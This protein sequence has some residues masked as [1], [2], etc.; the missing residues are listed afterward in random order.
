MN[1]RMGIAAI[2]A[3][4]ATMT[5]PASA[6][7]PTALADPVAAVR[8]IAPVPDGS[9]EGNLYVTVPESAAG[10]VTVSDATRGGPDLLIGLPSVLGN[11][12][13]RTDGAARSFGAK[14]FDIVVRP[15]S[16]SDDADVAI[17]VV[18]N[19]PDA[20]S[21]FDFELT[22]RDGTRTV[23]SDG[24]V[25]FLASDGGPVGVIDPPW[26]VDANGQAVKTW[27]SLAS[28]TLTLHVEHGGSA[29]PVVADPVYTNNC[30]FTTCSSYWSRGHTRSASYL[31]G[32]F[33]VAISWPWSCTY[34]PS[35]D[36]DAYAACL[37]AAYT[38]WAVS[39]S[40]NLTQASYYYK[41]IKLTRLRHTPILTWISTNNGNYCYSD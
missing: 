15:M 4:L 16:G 22:T 30:G 9:Q 23:L 19:G 33:T 29:Y 21:S 13:G 10:K 31:A 35:G 11:T 20:P 7:A 8:A 41:C 6:Q 32:I 34:I 17:Y 39:L 25:E 27:Y 14:D 38:L 2:G 36:A 37:S 5:V 40:A 18:L 12:A 3:V 26:G 28:T 24:A 1:M